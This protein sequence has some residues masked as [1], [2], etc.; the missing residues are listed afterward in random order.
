M[1]GGELK[2][3]RFVC[4]V[5]CG[6]PVNP[7]GVRAQVE[8]AVIYGLTATLKDAITVKD[9]RV[10]QSNFSDY[11]MLR[12][13]E[14]PPVEVHLVNSTEDPTGIGEPTVPV[15][16]PALCNAIYAATKKRLRRLPIR[17]EDLA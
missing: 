15:V 5:D 7:A 11:D 10:V 16:A 14:A 6:R 9:G 3:N 4:A 17:R 8:S 13:R 1:R 12:M 2:V